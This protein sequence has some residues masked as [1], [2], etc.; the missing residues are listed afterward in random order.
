MATCTR[1]PA[2]AERG[3]ADPGNRNPCP[4]PQEMP[5]HPTTWAQAGTALTARPTCSA[6]ILRSRC[7]SA[8]SSP[9][10][11]SSKLNSSTPS[12]SPP[13]PPSASSSSPAACCC[14]CL[15]CFFLPF[16]AKPRCGYHLKS[17]RASTRTAPKGTSTLGA[18]GGPP[19]RPA[20][21]PEGAAP[22]VARGAPT[23]A[24]DARGLPTD[25]RS[26]WRADGACRWACCRQGPHALATST[27]AGRSMPAVDT[28]GV[29]SHC[30]GAG[31][32]VAT[33]DSSHRHSRPLDYE[34]QQTMAE[35]SA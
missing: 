23:A 10:S 21:R 34:D 2:G 20:S 17:P 8:P 33:A 5:R 26:V 16:L 35:Q 4:A 3:R 6:V 15:P 1:T 28:A 9:S 12:A 7:S 18:E 24:N 11:R 30:G 19:A 22:S 31:S 27:V 25:C 32:S 14:C 29:A 13:P